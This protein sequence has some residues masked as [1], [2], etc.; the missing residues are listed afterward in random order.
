MGVPAV[1]QSHA[2]AGPCGAALGSRPPAQR[3]AAATPLVATS[4]GRAPL[5][6]PQPPGAAATA[7]RLGKPSPVL[8]VRFF[9]QK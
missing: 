6:A 2:A 5:P 1:Q 8:S 3:H 4:R 7:T 9:T